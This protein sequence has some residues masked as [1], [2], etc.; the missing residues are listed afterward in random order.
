M[1][2]EMDEELFQQMIA[3]KFWIC[4]LVESWCLKGTNNH[5]LKK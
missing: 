5:Q 4:N 1:E 2:P 3:Q